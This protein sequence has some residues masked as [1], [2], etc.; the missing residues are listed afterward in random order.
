MVLRNTL[1]NAL[2]SS[3]RQTLNGPCDGPGV[4]KLVETEGSARNLG[5]GEEDLCFLVTESV[6]YVG[7][8][9]SCTL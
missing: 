6:L 1:S 8:D 4:S 5:L 2:S 9:D 7:S 3:K